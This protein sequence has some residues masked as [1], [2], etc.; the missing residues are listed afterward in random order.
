M[1]KNS[2]ISDKE[3]KQFNGSRKSNKKGLK[4]KTM[5]N[6]NWIEFFILFDLKTTKIFLR[7]N[8]RTENL[9]LEKKTQFVLSIWPKKSWELRKL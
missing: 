1:K 2:T 5:A 9:F 6:N 8:E 3:A 4:A 7:G